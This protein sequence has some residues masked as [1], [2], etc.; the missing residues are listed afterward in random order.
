MSRLWFAFTARASHPSSGVNDAWILTSQSVARE[1]SDNSPYL[2]PNE[3]I[4][5]RIAEFLCLP[6][7]PFALMRRYPRHRGMFASLRF[8]IG[9]L[10]PDDFR[11]AVFARQHPRL[12]TGILLFDALIANEDRHAGNISVDN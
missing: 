6:V 2:I 10:P 1:N 11:P 12:T 7:P 8:G 9:D 3:W 4:S 5:G